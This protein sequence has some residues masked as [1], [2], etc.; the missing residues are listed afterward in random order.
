MPT[1][2]FQVQLP[3]YPVIP[4]NIG[5]VD[6]AGGYDTILKALAANQQVAQAPVENM[7]RLSQ[8]RTLLAR[9]QQEEQLR[10]LQTQAQGA[11][12]TGEIQQTPL[13]TNILGSQA[14]QAG[15]NTQLSTAQLPGQ[16]LAAGNETR[17]QTA[18]GNATGEQ[19]AIGLPADTTVITERDPNTGVLTEKTVTSKTIGD[20][21]YNTGEQTK[22]AP[23]AFTFERVAADQTG[24]PLGSVLYEKT[25]AAG[26]VG[27]NE[28][29]PAPWMGQLIQNTQTL[30]AQSMA[31]RAAGRTVEAD[32][33][34]SLIQKQIDT[35]RMMHGSKLPAAH[36]QVENEIRR[37]QEI[38]SHLDP[39]SDA[40]KENADAIS[41]L[42]APKQADTVTVSEL[43]PNADGGFTKTTKKIAVGAKPNTPLA[44]PAN[45]T[46]LVS[47]APAQKLSA[48]TPSKE[49]VVTNRQDF[50][51][52]PNGTPY[53]WNGQH[54]VKG[55]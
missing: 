28:V 44:R 24:M 48:P 41:R 19:L 7:Q 16:I 9:A 26:N 37:L 6:V 21:A 50:D 15:N 8:L 35:T 25:D 46:P 53:T 36:L 43:V 33:L 2:G 51:D 45:P 27:G 23:G 47:N 1:S 20:T 13:K 30:Q 55:Q 49:T 14:V 54:F 31:A 52:L 34:D 17:K 22:T 32:Q 29:K 40:Y 39:V 5:H 10:P 12:Y 3:Q 18:L 42:A 11:Q 4:S 38:N